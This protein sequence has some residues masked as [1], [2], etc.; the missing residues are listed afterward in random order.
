MFIIIMLI[1]YFIS[2]VLSLYKYWKINIFVAYRV[3]YIIT[4]K[5]NIHK[6]NGRLYCALIQDIKKSY[7]KI[8][9]YELPGKIIPGYWLFYNSKTLQGRGPI[10]SWLVWGIIPNDSTWNFPFSD[11]L[12][13]TEWLWKDS[14]ERHIDSI[15]WWVT[16]E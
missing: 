16:E 5:W 8:R 13:W 4:T 6:A 10:Q 1:T 7:L 3:L 11:V 14:T 2:L 12:L 9:M 15:V